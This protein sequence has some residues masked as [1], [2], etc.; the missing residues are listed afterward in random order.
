MR[1]GR[2]EY[3]EA[4]R[5]GR[6]V[7]SKDI[8]LTDAVATLERVGVNQNSAR[9]LVSNLRLLLDGQRYKRT[10]SEANTDDYLTWILRDYGEPYLR[11]A[12]SALEEHINYYK[13]VKGSTLPGLLKVLDK[14]KR[15]LKEA[16]PDFLSP[17]ETRF[18]PDEEQK[19][20]SEGRQ[21]IVIV[22]SYERSGKARTAC[23]KAHGFTCMVCGFDFEKVFGDIGNEFIHVHHLKDLASI[24]KEYEVNPIE[25]LRPVCPN[26]HAMLHKGPPYTINELKVIIETQRNKQNSN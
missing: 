13:T 4:Y 26:C 24:G 10:L 19:K 15:L 5:V 25:D 8:R 9:D 11:N 1:I 22:N 21:K 6:K 20:F 14:H 3:E 2:K 16:V 23:L 17:E 7:Y 18:A 12:L